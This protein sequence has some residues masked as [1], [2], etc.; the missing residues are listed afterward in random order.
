METPQLAIRVLSLL[1]SN[2][3]AFKSQ[4]L[5]VPQSTSTINGRHFF[6][7]FFL[8]LKSSFQN[9][10]GPN[11]CRGNEEG[12]KFQIQNYSV[13]RVYDSVAGEFIEI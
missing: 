6:F 5:N 2:V 9:Y 13:F 11:T 12:G 8:L 10:T 1:E 3:F 7:F 4:G